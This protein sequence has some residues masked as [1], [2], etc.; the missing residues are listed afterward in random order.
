MLCF[1]GAQNVVRLWT[2]EMI[3]KL[4]LYIIYEQNVMG[5]HFSESTAYSWERPE[6][7]RR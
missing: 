3:K 5:K 4:I 1:Q 7:F 6:S 2:Y